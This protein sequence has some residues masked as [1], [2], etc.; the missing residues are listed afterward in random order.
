MKLSDA[1]HRF[2]EREGREKPARAARERT[3][4]LCE[5]IIELE[6]RLELVSVFLASALELLNVR[7]AQHA[8]TLELVDA[9]VRCDEILAADDDRPSLAVAA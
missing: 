7:A 1:E 3:E 4:Y 5:R 9:I 6:D 8:R 2:I